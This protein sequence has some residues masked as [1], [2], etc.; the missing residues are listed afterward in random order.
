MAKIFKILL[1]KF[2]VIFSLEDIPFY[3][4]ILFF[5]NIAM[6]LSLITISLNCFSKAVYEFKRSSAPNG[7]YDVVVIES[8]AGVLGSDFSEV[9][10][11]SKDSDV[12]EDKHFKVGKCFKN[13]GEIAFLLEPN[14]IHDKNFYGLEPYWVGNNQI[15]LEHNGCEYI[16]FKPE[17]IFDSQ[18][19]KILVKSIYEKKNYNTTT[20]KSISGINSDNHL[21]KKLPFWKF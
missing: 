12:V 8:S 1:Y 14:Y 6:Q 19:F 5:F 4:S 13:Q 16:E 2:K 20:K 17:V 18:I 7:K 21:K 3:I 9:Y 10:I 11:V 15:V